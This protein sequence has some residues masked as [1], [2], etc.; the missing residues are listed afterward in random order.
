M[1]LTYG[2]YDS[3][4]GDRVYDAE[5][6]GSI[7]DGVITDGVYANI[8]NRFR[9]TAGSGLR[10]I[11]GTGRAWFNHTWTLLDAAM[12]I[13]LP[14][15]DLNNPRIDAVC[16]V[17]DKTIV[18]A[19]YIEIVSGTPNSTP[20]KPTISSQNNVYRYP[21]AYVTVPKGATVPG[22]IE[23]AVGNGL[24]TPL[25]ITP[26]SQVTFDDI[27]DVDALQAEWDAYMVTANDQLSAQQSDFNSWLA[28]LDDALADDPDNVAGRLQGQ[29]S[30]INWQIDNNTWRIGGIIDDETGDFII[31]DDDE[32]LSTAISFVIEDEL[33]DRLSKTMELDKGTLIPNNSDLDTYTTPGNYYVPASANASTIANTPTE[34]SGYSLKV[35][36]HYTDKPFQLAIAQTVIYW[37]YKGSTWSSWYIFA[38]RTWVE[39]NTASALNNIFKAVT[40]TYQYTVPANGTLSITADN[41]GYS[42]PEGYTPIGVIYATSG[43]SPYVGVDMFRASTTSGTIMVV[44]NHTSTARTYTASI[45]VT[46]AKS[47]CF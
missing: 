34:N 16:L 7:F 29:I 10:V 14:S 47:D 41:F 21:L 19:N 8:G 26:T 18:R 28:D 27:V 40:Y 9:V 38:S 39:S 22:S 42:Y 12:E 33:A 4:N 37:R 20:A 43:D 31:T 45:C 36:N 24:D 30:K 6:F 5:Q 1:S 46:F 2:F 23:Q 15:A 44:R 25:I 3:V 13:D 17:V 32:T 11:V 35:F